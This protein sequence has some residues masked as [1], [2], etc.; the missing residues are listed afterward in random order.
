VVINPIPLRKHPFAIPSKIAAMAPKKQK[1]DVRIDFSGLPNDITDKKWTNN[2]L[3]DLCR[4]H[5]LT[6]SGKK[7]EL[8]KRLQDEAGGQIPGHG[9][10]DD[11]EDED[12]NAPQPAP[13]AKAKS[14]K[15][16]AKEG[17]KPLPKAPAYVPKPKAAPKAPK[18]GYKAGEVKNNGKPPRKDE[19]G[20]KEKPGA[21]PFRKDVR[22]TAAEKARAKEYKGS[23]QNLR[24]KLRKQ[25][26]QMGKPDVRDTVF[27]EVYEDLQKA[28]DALDKVEEAE[29]VFDEDEEEETLRQGDV[30]NAIE[31]DC[32]DAPASRGSKRKSSGG[33]KESPAAKRR[34]VEAEDGEQEVEQEDGQDA[35]EEEEEAE[36]EEDE[37]EER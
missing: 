20:E 10:G 22:A 17:P 37:E 29:E 11:E 25:L 24:K 23:I 33:S 3:K 32:E 36:A 13:K 19:S 5:R 35:A 16:T 27:A 1:T 14:K 6:V 28:I 9:E 18:N 21:K 26:G 4:Y 31:E 15:D 30:A 8:I 12:E 34:Y 7:H 2:H